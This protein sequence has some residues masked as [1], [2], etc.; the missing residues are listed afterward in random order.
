LFEFATDEDGVLIKKGDVGALFEPAGL[1]DLVEHSY[2]GTKTR[3]AIS[4]TKVILGVQF[5]SSTMGFI[6]MLR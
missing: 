2:V 1:L 5:M 6:Q 3:N 4:L